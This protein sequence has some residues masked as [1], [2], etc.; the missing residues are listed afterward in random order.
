MMVSR[1]SSRQRPDA[2]QSQSL[3]RPINEAI[4]VVA[5]ISCPVSQAHIL[6]LL[7]ESKEQF[8]PLELCSLC[9]SEIARHPMSLPSDP[10]ELLAAV[11]PSRER[12]AQGS[13]QSEYQRNKAVRELSEHSQVKETFDPRKQLPKVF[14][15]EYESK[16][17]ILAGPDQVI[18]IRL[19]PSVLHSSVSGEFSWVNANI[20]L[21][22]NI[23]WNEAK[24]L[25]SEHW[26]TG[27]TNLLLRSLY[28]NLKQGS[29]QSVNG[30]ANEFRKA[31]Q[32]NDI[33]EDQRTCE[34]FQ[35]KLRPEL[36]NQVLLQL[37]LREQAAGE[38]PAQLTLQVIEETARLVDPIYESLDHSPLPSSIKE[39]HRN[40]GWK[41]SRGKQ[42]STSSPSS[43]GKVFH[44]DNHPKSTNHSTAECRSKRQK[45]Y[46][47]EKLRPST[48][49]TPQADPNKSKLTPKDQA[50]IC[51][52]CKE[53]APGH[54]PKDCPK[55]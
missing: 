12:V 33:K 39:E 25:F 14:L 22:P 7:Q 36:R 37:R 13:S 26:R 23:T 51:I 1:S 48:E 21:V 15:Q 8:D 53:K 2:A 28:D 49:S 54:Y 42:S 50:W 44:C 19:L 32:L 11:F 41:R 18:W 38:N 47:S 34:D 9:R 4:P 29:Q 35:I 45:P 6:F 3:P 31:M 40:G 17:S 16:M 5:R 10:P 52:K 43:D 24:R 27:N 46:A 30:F 20:S 55:K